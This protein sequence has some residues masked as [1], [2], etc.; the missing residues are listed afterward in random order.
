VEMAQNPNL[1]NLKIRY[2][3]KTKRKQQSADLNK[4]GK[5]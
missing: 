1:W 5:D 3:F 2:F 4:A